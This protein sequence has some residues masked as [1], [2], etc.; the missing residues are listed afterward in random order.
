MR[1]SFRIKTVFLNGKCYNKPNR[2]VIFLLK[3]IHCADLHLDRPFEGLHQMLSESP[4]TQ[5]INEAVFEK[6]IQMAID[7]KVDFLLLAGD[8]FHQSRPS[9][10]TQHFFFE[11]IQRLE[12]QDIFV[13]MIFGNHD[14]YD[15]S[16]YWF[17]FPKNVILLQ[18]EQV[19]TKTAQTK[20]GISYAISGFSYHQPWITTNKISEFPSK[21][22]TYHIGLY[23]G[24]QGGE[25][26]APFALQDMK[27]KR[28]DY[29]ALGH[30]HVPLTLSQEPP[31]YYAGTPQG[32]NKKEQQV[33]GVRLVTLN[34]SQIQTE[35]HAVHSLLWQEQTVSLRGLK[36]QKEVLEKLSLNWQTSEALLI[37]LRLQ[38]TDELPEQWLPTKEKPEVLA[39]LNEKLKKQGLAQRIFNLIIEQTQKEVI[40]IPASP[41]L[42][43]QLLKNYQDPAVFTTIIADLLSHPIGKNILQLDTLQKE[44]L[45]DFSATLQQDYQWNEGRNS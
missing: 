20:Q 8:T 33:G 12:Q 24:E 6:I 42:V 34:G 38:D 4:T 23:H 35:L 43:E 14:Y 1:T 16:R 27:N 40:R 28:Y 11:Q 9:L 13:Y 7:E 17:E 22:A 3:F 30:I 2:R 5:K 45:A 31:I 21:S 18:E 37:Q 32:H 10:K 26:Y 29:W 44:A 36:T 41:S 15:E 19:M 25:N 39:Y